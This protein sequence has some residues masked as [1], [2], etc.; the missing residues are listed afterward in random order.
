MIKCMPYFLHTFPQNEVRKGPEKSKEETTTDQFKVMVV[1]IFSIFIFFIF[2][3][4]KF[5][6]K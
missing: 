2:V 1:D 6:I 4:F 5:N 3:I